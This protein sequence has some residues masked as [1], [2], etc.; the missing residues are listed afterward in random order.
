MYN[1]LKF[2]STVKLKETLYKKNRL[3][4][5]E[6]IPKHIMEDL[7]IDQYLESMS[8]DLILRISSLIA[9]EDKVEKK[10]TSTTTLDCEYMTDEIKFPMNWWECL[11]ERFAPKWVLRRHPVDYNYFVQTINKY[12]TEHNTYIENRTTFKADIPVPKG[13]PD[14]FKTIEYGY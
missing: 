6:R 14:Y 1:Q 3:T 7:E 12:I 13:K 11:K 5:Q 8:G 4:F 2:D 9:S 10:E